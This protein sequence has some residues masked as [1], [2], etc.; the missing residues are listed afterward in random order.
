MAEHNSRVVAVLAK[1]SDRDTHNIAA[2]DLDRT[3]GAPRPRMPCHLRPPL[4]AASTPPSPPPRSPS[5]AAAALSPL[6]LYAACLSPLLTAPSPL[7][8]TAP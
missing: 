7:L 6:L 3:I 5:R 4:P 2:E 1:L 8:L